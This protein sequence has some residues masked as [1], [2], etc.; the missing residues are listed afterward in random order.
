MPDN[1]MKQKRRFINMADEFVSYFFSY[2][3]A[4]CF[5]F[6]GDL[7]TA[8]FVIIRLFSLF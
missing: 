4:G 7:K 6:S 2:R 3:D 8:E 5:N 1:Y